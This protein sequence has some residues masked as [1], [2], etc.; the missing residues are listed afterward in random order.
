M[1]YLPTYS[2][3]VKTATGKDCLNFEN[4]FKVG[5]CFMETSKNGSLV[6]AIINKHLRNHSSGSSICAH[7]GVLVNWHVEYL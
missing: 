2:I 3:T 7:M 6:I 5:H 4:N 1:D